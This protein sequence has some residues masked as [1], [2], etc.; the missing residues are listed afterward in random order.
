M[1]KIM[2]EIFP[3]HGLYYGK[4]QNEN[5][6][7]L[8]EILKRLTFGLN[9]QQWNNFTKYYHDSSIEKKDKLL[10]LD[11]LNESINENINE[12]DKT[13]GQCNS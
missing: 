7:Q 2:N 3:E 5:I 4:L 9:Y 8:K 10:T 1:E 11:I 12:P 6:D 13:E